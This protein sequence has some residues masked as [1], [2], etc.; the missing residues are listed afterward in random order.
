MASASAT[1]ALLTTRSD[2]TEAAAATAG[3][4]PACTQ[5]RPVASRARAGAAQFPSSSRPEPSTPPGVCGAPFPRRGSTCIERLGSSRTAASTAALI[6]AH[7]LACWSRGAE[8]TA[9]PRQSWGPAPQ[10]PTASRRSSPAV[11]STSRHPRNSPFTDRR[12]QG[13]EVLPVKHPRARPADA[14][15]PPRTP[16][17]HERSTW[18]TRSV[19]VTTRS[20][21]G[22]ERSR[23]WLGGR[24]S[25]RAGGH[26]RVT[27]CAAVVLLVHPGVSTRRSAPHG[28][29]HRPPQPGPHEQRT[30]S[31]GGQR[32]RRCSRP[33]QTLV[34][35]A[36]GARAGSL[37]SRRAGSDARPGPG[38]PT[39]GRWSPPTQ[40]ADCGVH[41]GSAQ[42]RGTA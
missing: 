19:V 20:S 26:S 25:R 7:C 5:A 32:R 38:P 34:V 29:P 2:T 22:E 18:V 9:G 8:L 15:R 40:P 6:P 17:T 30:S 39:A 31:T 28:C 36:P 33:G 24:G 37:G 42:G 41:A 35:P 1:T 23:G 11:Q 10:A 27:P 3:C 13:D 12:V 14:S 21:R 16:S 4:R